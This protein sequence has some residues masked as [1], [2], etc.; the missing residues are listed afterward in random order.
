MARRLVRKLKWP[1]VIV[2]LPALFALGLFVYMAEWGNFHVVT[3]GLAYRSGQMG[4]DNLEYYLE[5]YQIKSVINLRGPDP[6]QPWYQ[7]ETGVCRSRGVAHYDC[8]FYSDHAPQPDQ[9]AKLIALFASAPR[10]VLMHCR[11][12]ADRAGLAAAIWK[13]VVEKRPK[14]EA[15]KQ[16]SILYGHMPL[17]GSTALDDFFDQW[18]PAVGDPLLRSP[19]AVPGDRGG[20]PEKLRGGK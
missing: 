16:L 8:R 15:R 17:G 3:P 10:P 2:G 18:Q 4:R 6:G 1:F 5:K 11:V 19:H 12:G 20:V 9:L 7:E 14:A 13:V